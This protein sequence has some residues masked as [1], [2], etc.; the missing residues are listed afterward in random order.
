[1]TIALNS[2]QRQIDMLYIYIYIFKKI[3]K[4][5]AVFAVFYYFFRFTS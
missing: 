4:Q 2:L 5:S 3:N 1:M